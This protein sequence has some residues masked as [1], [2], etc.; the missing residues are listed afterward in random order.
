MKKRLLSLVLCLVMVFALFPVLQAPAQAADANGITNP[1]PQPAQDSTKQLNLTKELKPAAD[2]TYSIDLEAW[3][4]GTVKQTTEKIPTDFVIVVDQSGSMMTQDMAQNYTPVS[5]TRTI[6][7]IADEN[8]AYY[9]QADDGNYYRVYAVRD[10]LFEYFAPNTKWSGSIVEDAN[11]SASFWGTSSTGHPDLQNQYYYKTDDGIYRPVSVH[12][13]GGAFSFVATL[14]YVDENDNT[15]Y[16]R[17]AARP[18]YHGAT[19]N[20]YN[21]GDS[22]YNLVHGILGRDDL[23]E[24][25][26]DGVNILGVKIYAGTY[27]NYPMYKRHVGYTKLCYR[28]VDGVVHTI[29]ATNNQSEWE[30][31]NSN[32]Q[33]ITTK[34]GS[35]RPAY[36]NLFTATS[37]TTRLASLKEA[38]TSFAN[39]VAGEV[40]SF[41]LVDNRVSIIGFSSTNDSE[42]HDP[43]V[44]TSSSTAYYNTEL[45][46]GTTFD[47]TRGSAI[48][49]N[50]GLSSDGYNH[51][52]KQKAAAT[53][54]DYAGALVAA[55]NGTAGTVNQE[56]TDAIDAVT[57]Y[58]GTQPEDGLDMALNVLANRGEG[59]GKTTYTI[60]SGPKKDQVVN[61]N[62]VVIFFTDGQ[63]GNYAISNQYLEAND[64]IESAKSLK[65]YG[66]RIFSIGVF[67]ES[68]VNALPYTENYGT[69]ED[70]RWEYAGG[71]VKNVQSS[72]YWFQLRRQWRPGNAAG[73]TE[74]PND[75]IFDY[76][77]VTSSN[78]PNAEEYIDAAW[79]GGTFSGNYIAA[80]DGVRHK[81]TAESTN[82]YY[83]MASNQATL[84]DAFLQAATMMSEESGSE[85]LLDDTAVFKDEINLDDFDVS[86]ATY[87]VQWQPV[88]MA[89][90]ALVNNGDP[91][92][93]VPATSVPEED[94]VSIVEYSGFN[95][96]SEEF[97]VTASSPG[98][99]LVVTI[100]G[101]TPKKATGLLYSNKD[102]EEIYGAGIY[103]AGADVPAV[104][105]ASPT[106]ELTGGEKSYVIDFNAPMTVATNASILGTTTGTNG[107]FTKSGTDVNYQLKAIGAEANKT[108]ALALSGV[109]TAM[110]Y[111]KPAQV[112]GAAVGWNKITTIPASSVYF[113]D[114]FATAVAVG[115]GSGYNAGA[116]S[117]YVAGAD[118]VTTVDG[119]ST[120]TFTFYGTAIDVYCTTDSESG[121]IQS[122][123]DGANV[124]T[125]KNQSVDMVHYN[126]PTIHYENLTAGE[127]HTLELIVRDTAKYKLDGIRVYNPISDQETYADTGEANAT[128]TTLRD[129]LING[130]EDFEYVEGH[131]QSGILYI[132]STAGLTMTSTDEDGNTVTETKT[133]FEAYKQ[134][135]PKNELYLAKDQGIAF[136]VTNYSALA[137]TGAKIRVGLSTAQDDQSAEV[138]FSDGN[139]AV[140]QTVSSPLDMYYVLTPAEVAADGSATFMIVN[141]S[142]AL[143]SVTKLKVSGGTAPAE[144]TLDD[145][146]LVLSAD[147]EE[148]APNTLKLNVVVNDATMRYAANFLSLG[149]PTAPEAPAEPDPDP[150]Q[151]LDLREVA[152]QL[153]SEFVSRLFQSISG[154]FNV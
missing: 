117:T 78:Y 36:N 77:S 25:A 114:D 51:N 100:N 2:G 83:R 74:E 126:V 96:A 82:K 94:G 31:C 55:T 97:Y 93:K 98:Y 116:A 130:Q 146:A 39:E 57:A 7:Q 145:G 131:A 5:G 134:N 49:Q 48:P 147:A 136:T 14:W 128:Y 32:G 123:L 139:G 34:D 121:Y 73:Y 104:S 124:K 135:G 11:L 47:I 115:D 10:Y 144:F 102:G 153:L 142:E 151:Q 27:I 112:T 127:L 70:S 50:S 133:G 17:H 72:N 42:T 79:I 64:V 99:K 85:V 88:R 150:I 35:T 22:F 54:A 30:Y 132:D 28:D 68:H 140:A 90:G 108:S 103:G 91:I 138:R 84:I 92:E 152:R 86:N 143:V 46:T 1:T 16:F 6:E 122:K 53:A 129:L 65:D 19:G 67:G 40:D 76:M 26:Y 33:A 24:Y 38:L 95:Y 154:L 62:T 110:V 21:D 56:I 60:R 106:L 119:K 58:G 125:V 63:P 75:T 18:K 4:T 12:L 41:G 107:A 101:L 29:N 66:A 109:D 120:F 8:A 9:I 149:A 44:V 87:T 61:R 71:W 69:S 45:L 148:P 105:I 13:Q 23:T 20:D 43:S 141:T 113:D 118:Q 15:V 59:E 137:A 81:D 80:T 52:G 111:G 37:M 89:S 3:S